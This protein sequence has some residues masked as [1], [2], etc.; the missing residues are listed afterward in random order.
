MSFERR[1]ECD[2]CNRNRRKR[3]REEVWE[4]ENFK[5]RRRLNGLREGD[6]IRIFSGGDQID[7]IGVFIRIENRFLIWVDAA[8]NLNMTS[9]DAISVQRVV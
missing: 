7:G 1:C 5:G 3:G 9:L 4:W 2:E 6:K 8:V